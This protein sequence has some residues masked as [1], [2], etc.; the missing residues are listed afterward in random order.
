MENKPPEAICTPRPDGNLKGQ[1]GRIF[2]VIL[3]QGSVLQFLFTEQECIGNFTPKGLVVLAVYKFNMPLLYKNE[4]TICYTFGAP[5]LMGMAPM[6]V[7]DGAPLV[8]GSLRY[9]T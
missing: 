7:K 9:L 5:L 4:F 2:Q 6:V 8:V 3:N 1:G